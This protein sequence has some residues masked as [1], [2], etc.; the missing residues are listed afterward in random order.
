MPSVIALAII[1]LQVWTHMYFVV[2]T[3]KYGICIMFSIKA[4]YYK[5]PI[6]MVSQSPPFLSEGKKGNVYKS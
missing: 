1:Y 3:Q 5:T 6:P 4:C 2:N